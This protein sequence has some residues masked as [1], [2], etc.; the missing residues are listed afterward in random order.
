MA[1]IVAAIL[2]TVAFAI[3]AARVGVVESSREAM[4]SGGTVMAVLRDPALDDDT[5]EKRM[6]QL[7]LRL[8]TLFGRIVLRVSLAFAGPLLALLLLDRLGIV[9]LA[10]VERAGLSWPLLMFYAL[11]IVS[12]P[13][14]KRTAK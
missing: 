12:I 9:A 14:L 8:L 2:F 10:A 5:K 7:S 4:R 13:F 11:L 3:I 6:Q 1:A